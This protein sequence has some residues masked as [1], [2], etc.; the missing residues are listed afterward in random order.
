MK[1]NNN[2]IAIKEHLKD[3]LLYILWGEISHDYFDK[4]ANWIYTRIN[5]NDKVGNKVS[6]TEDEKERL[7]GALTDI[8]NKI[9][10]AV[11]NL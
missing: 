6:F 1:T 10:K 7:K 3:I 5:G 2:D 4:D 9:R 11:D 8:S